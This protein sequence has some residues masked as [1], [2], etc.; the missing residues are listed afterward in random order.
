[1]F[2]VLLSYQEVLV[3]RDG[4]ALPSGLVFQVDRSVLQNLSLLVFLVCQVVLE[5]QA[6]LFLLYARLLQVN[7]AIQRL[8]V[9]PGIQHRPFLLVIPA[10]QV[11][12]VHRP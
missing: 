4:Q 2:P 6:I 7:Q 5:N 12:Q 11:F 1:M 10:V 9:F 3:A 8:L